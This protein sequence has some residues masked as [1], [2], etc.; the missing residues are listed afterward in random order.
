MS[1][2][3]P[4]SLRA[5]SVIILLTFSCIAG[6]YT[7][8]FSEADIQEKVSAMMPLQRKRLFVTIIITQPVVKL[9]KNVNKISI[10]AN[11]EALAGGHR[12]TGNM[13]IT[14]ALTY[15]KKNG[16]FHLKDPAISDMHIDRIQQQYQPVIKD[17]AQSAMAK[18]LASRPVYTLQD[19]NIR[20]KLAKSALESISVNDGKLVVV[21][22]LF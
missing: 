8:E 13:T 6:A 7:V 1:S 15:N 20:H 5:A 4:N 16:T 21:F 12:G 17:I 11:L 19:D 22:S 18:T 10:K 3:F 2:L 9:L 14:G